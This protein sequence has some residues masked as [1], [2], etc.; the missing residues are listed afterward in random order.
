[1]RGQCTPRLTT[2]GRLVKKL[3]RFKRERETGRVW[4]EGA[5]NYARLAVDLILIALS[6]FIALFIRDNFVLWAPKVQ[7]ILLYALFCVVGAAIVFSAVR[8][9]RTL[10]R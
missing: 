5:R 3:L 1:M 8:L 4:Y 6:P 10:W 9:H 7:G 2:D